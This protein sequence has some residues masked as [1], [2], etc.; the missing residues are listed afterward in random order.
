MFRSPSG[1][2]VFNSSIVVIARIHALIIRRYEFTIA[3]R[4]VVSLAW[5]FNSKHFPVTLN[6]TRALFPVWPSSG[7]MDLA[8]ESAIRWEERRRAMIALDT[9]G[10]SCLQ[11]SC[12]ITS[13]G[14]IS[15]LVAGD[16]TTN[17]V[18]PLF[19]LRM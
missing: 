9:I 4:V 7:L 2:Y 19:V 3:L 11:R 17:S 16:V 1:V 14:P 13:L 15:R 12:D 10:Y 8:I 6:L 18:D 5:N